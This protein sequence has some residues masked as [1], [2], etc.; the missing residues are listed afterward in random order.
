MI[1]ASYGVHADEKSHTGSCVILGDM[2]AV[3]C[4]SSKQGIVTKSS[5]EAELVALSDSCNHG[6]HVR[7]FI[8][9][10]G[11]ASNPLRVFQD[12]MSCMA[13]VRRGRSAAEKTRHTDIRYFWVKER[14]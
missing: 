1:D 10:Q 9:A 2:G 3:H 14:V 12:N 11:Y 7:R 5:T 6:M 4:R 8:V 13:L